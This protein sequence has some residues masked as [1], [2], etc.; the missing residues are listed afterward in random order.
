M[1]TNIENK[2]N[3]YF[4]TSVALDLKLRR[5]NSMMNMASCALLQMKSP[6]HI[7]LVPV[8]VM[9]HLLSTALMVKSS[10][11]TM[12]V[13]VVLERVNL[14]RRQCY[15]EVRHTKSRLRCSI[16]VAVIHVKVKVRKFRTLPFIYSVLEKSFSIRCHTSSL[17]CRC[18]SLDVTC[19][20]CAIA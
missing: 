11:M 10:F 14:L 16:L 2:I 5:L 3:I 8:T 18:F 7:V 6:L 12:N 4:Q 17:S 20:K 15:V 1:T 13:N 19:S 9:T